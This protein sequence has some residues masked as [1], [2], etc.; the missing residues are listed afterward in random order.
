M[1]EDKI[2]NNKYNT[3]E[4]EFE[5]FG[6]I[7]VNEVHR[8]KDAF[9]EYIESK[10]QKDL[11]EIFVKSDFYEEYSKVKKVPRGDTAR[12]FYYFVDRLVVD[13]T[14]SAIEKFV[15]IAEFMSMSYEVLYEEI[16]P[17]HKEEI[18]RELDQ[19][20]A[21]FKRRKIHRLF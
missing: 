4:V 1:K 17:S 19:K 11:Y 20:Y 21:I 8:P 6:K 16:S 9:D 14:S 2:F 18:L 13:G 5:A 7:E 15:N 3:G 10:M 12:V